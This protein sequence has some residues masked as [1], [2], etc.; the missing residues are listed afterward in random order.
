MRA[1]RV[2]QWCSLL[3]LAAGIVSCAQPAEPPEGVAPE[4]TAMDAAAEA[5]ASYVAPT[6]EAV[7][8]DLTQAD[9][10][11]MMEDL[12]NWGRWGADDE[13]GAS[14]L[15][16]L[17]KRREAIAL[18]KAG[19][20]V[21]LAHPLLK[22]EAPDV[23]QPFE[24]AMFGVPDPDQEPTFMGG[25]GDRY[26]IS[27]HGYSHSHLDALCHL[28]YKGQDYNGVSYDVVTPAG[29]VKGG[30][31][32]L[33]NGV[34]TRGVLYDIPRLKGV[35]YLE[36]GTP[37]YMED[38]EA[39][40]V[41]SGAKARPG[42]AVFI[43]TG[44]WARRAE[45]GPWNVATSEAGLHASTAPWLHARDVAFVGSD[46]ALDVMPSQIEG[47]GLPVHMLT[48]IAMGVNLFDNQDLEALAETAAAQNRWEFMLVA[49]PLAVPGGT[50]SPI[51]AIAIF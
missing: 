15:V 1:T 26:S 39:W 41:M 43:R 3:G 4:A 34:V 38:L 33:R 35:P 20:T 50:G 37:I 29:C 19:L 7:S 22:E 30:I 46:S 12:S 48:I 45:V 13:L 8:H 51:N 42:D 11:H 2:V 21:S 40:E 9:I 49:G 24:H 18:A 5:A 36:P 10:E 25:A 6:V 44:R 27:Y 31:E 23:P 28:S 17:A 14:N 32:N 16:T 47:V